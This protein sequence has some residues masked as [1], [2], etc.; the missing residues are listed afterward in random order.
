[1]NA[2]YVMRKIMGYKIFFFMAIFVL[3]ISM[4]ESVK[5]FPFPSQMI[6]MTDGLISQYEELGA[7]E[8]VDIEQERRYFL[9]LRMWVSWLLQFFIVMCGIVAGISLILRKNNLGLMLTILV[10]TTYLFIWILQK[11]A[12]DLEGLLAYFRNFYY[13]SKYQETLSIF[14]I[15]EVLVP[16]GYLLLI[17]FAILLRKN[18]KLGKMY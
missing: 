3:V 13:F 4:T 7:S 9:G 16:L 15:Y 6:E 11:D 5:L 12:W 1:M 17:F 14:M 18:K 2:D 8:N 10:S